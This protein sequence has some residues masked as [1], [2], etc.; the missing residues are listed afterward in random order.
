MSTVQKVAAD[1]IICDR[2]LAWLHA[3]PIASLGVY[4]PIR[5]E[6]DLHAL[7][8]VLSAQGVHLSLPIILGQDQALGFVRWTPGDA[9]V[10]DTLGTS[11]PVERVAVQPQALLIPCLGFNAERI[12]LGYGGGFYDRTLA[13]Q[14]R[15][16][17]IGVA[18]A[19]ALR[20]FPGEPHDMVLDVI[21]TGP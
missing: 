6:P 20:E 15:P 1:T 21:I 7:Y 10:K 5:K 3:H 18:Y 16:L 2:V 11:V 13:L 14:P 4:H 9:L 19:H 17:A 12:R 8:N